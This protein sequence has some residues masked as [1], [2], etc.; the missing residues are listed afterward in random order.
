MA[1]LGAVA[2]V[3]FS[4]N[5]VASLY[6]GE[7]RVPTVPSAPVIASVVYDGLGSMQVTFTPPEN[8][9]GSEITGYAVQ[10]LSPDWTS[11]GLVTAEDGVLVVGGEWI[12]EDFQI[13]A[14][15]EVGE[16]LRSAPV[17]GTIS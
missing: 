14:V 15:N 16:G 1:R 8:D 11:D 9:G 17:T 12:G 4:G 6:V 7:E 3:V 2:G 10:V 5:E 13:A